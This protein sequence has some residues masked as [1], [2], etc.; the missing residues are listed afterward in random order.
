MDDRGG[1]RICTCG[2]R[3][4]NSIESQSC[5][6]T[7][8]PVNRRKVARINDKVYYELYHKAISK[9]TAES[10][11]LRNDLDLLFLCDDISLL[12]LLV[13]SKGEYVRYIE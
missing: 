3:P 13:N 7:Y 5:N 10:L 6:I 8:V 11:K 4:P 9:V 2:D 1:Q 12:P